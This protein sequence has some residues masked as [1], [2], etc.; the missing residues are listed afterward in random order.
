[1]ADGVQAGLDRDALR[2]LAVTGGVRDF[3]IPI[4]E[5]HPRAV[6]RYLKLLA[7]DAAQDCLEVTRDAL[8]LEGVFAVGRELILDQDAPAGSERQSFDVIVLR[9]AG[10]HL[11]DGL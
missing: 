3:L 8:D 1:H 10:E 4:E 11:E 5:L 9:G 6:D 7:L 2:R